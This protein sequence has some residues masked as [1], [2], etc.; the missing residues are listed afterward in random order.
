[1]E[2]NFRAVA[3]SKGKQAPNMILYAG[4]FIQGG[5]EIT[6]T[7][8]DLRH[9]IKNFNDGVGCVLDE[10]GEYRIQGNYQHAKYE[11]NPES[12]RASGWGYNLKMKNGVVMADIDWTDKAIEFIENEE[13]QYISPEFW[14]NWKDEK[15]VEHGFTI[16]GFALTNVPFLKEKQKPV[17]LTEVPERMFGEI[18]DWYKNKFKRDDMRYK[19]ADVM[20]GYADFIIAQINA[21]TIKDENEL[22]TKLVTTNQEYMQVLKLACKK[23]EKDYQMSEKLMKE[24]NVSDADKLDAAVIEMKE[25]YTVAQAELDALKKEKTETENKFIELSNKVA[26]LE[27][28]ANDKEAAAFYDKLVNAGKATPAQRE[29]YIDLYLKDKDFANKF[30]EDLPVVVDFNREAGSGEGR[31]IKSAKDLEQEMMKRYSRE[32]K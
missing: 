1:M 3:R 17:Q 13:M 29:K 27:K 6:V 9:A 22:I 15:G 25:K 24:F 7:E 10:N 31:Q 19:V 12:S 32:N 23:E 28:E 4:E 5:R 16:V 18:E 21:G 8:K 11:Q 2:H 26:E 30:I 20:L 14:E